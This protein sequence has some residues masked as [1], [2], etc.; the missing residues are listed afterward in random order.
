MLD[1]V[2]ESR[3]HDS[4]NELTQRTIGQGG[5][6]D[7]SYDDAG[8]LVQDGSANGDHQYVWDYR[9]RLIQAKEK[10][11]GDW[12]TVGTYKYDPQGRRIRKVV[13]NKGGLNGTTRFLWGGDSD[14]QC[15]EER[16]GSDDLVARFTYS[17][18][19]MDAV[20]V[21]ERDLNADSDFGDTNEVVYYQA[22][23][24]FSVYALSDADGTVVERYRYDAYGGCTVLDADGSADGDGLSDVRNPYVFTGRRLDP[25]TGLMQYRHRYYSTGLGRFASRDPLS[26]ADSLNLFGY[27]GGRTTAGRDPSGMSTVVE[28][29]NPKLPRSFML[30]AGRVS[31]RITIT[32]TVWVLYNAK[33][34]AIFSEG[35]ARATLSCP[36]VRF[37]RQ[38]GC[39]AG[40]SGTVSPQPYQY[41]YGH[42]NP[43]RGLDAL[44]LDDA[45]APPIPFPLPPGVPPIFDLPP[46]DKDPG[47][48]TQKEIDALV[49]LC[50]LPAEIGP[51]GSD[52]YW[53]ALCRLYVCFIKQLHMKCQKPEA[54]ADCLG[55]DMPGGGFKG[56]FMAYCDR[57]CHKLWKDGKLD[58]EGLLDCR[59]KCDA[60]Y[61]RRKEL[62]EGKGEGNGSQYPPPV[63]AE[64]SH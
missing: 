26:Y 22:N 41:W 43:I 15:L 57:C 23:T 17:P 24:L 36:V 6:I 3:V 8:N 30:R 29:G 31:M 53:G 52:E 25:E 39:K 2:T 51:P 19:Y 42:A 33:G 20:A 9:N 54:V 59:E 4:V 27:A 55:C 28:I 62:L 45:P 49:S 1:S 58:L 18:D 21:Q 35:T 16:D 13:T 5:A 7:L 12:N 61:K 40:G 50:S 48:W 14:W 56:L 47:D 38:G 10:Q 37:T 63:G 64:P 34:Q 46:L 32:G 60:E 44:G 11:S